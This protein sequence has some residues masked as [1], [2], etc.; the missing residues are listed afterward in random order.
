M[1][2][3][4]KILVIDASI[5]GISGDMF[6]GALI[7][8]GANKKKVI[9]LRDFILRYVEGVKD[10]DITVKDVKRREFRAKK[11]IIKAVD[12]KKYRHGK[13]VIDSIVNIVNELDL[14]SK[15]KEFAINTV[16]TLVGVEAM[17]HG[18]SVDEVHLHEAGLADTIVDIV[19]SAIALDDLKL[20]NAKIYVTPVAVGG[21][22]IKISH[23]IITSPAPATLEI[24]KKSNIHVIGG[25]IKAELT[26]PTGASLL[27]NLV[28]EATLF[29]PHLQV[30]RVG[31]GAGDKDFKEIPNILRV[32]LGSKHEA[33]KYEEIMVIETDI[34]DVTGEV[35]GYLVD[36]LIAEG[37]KDVSIIPI[38]RKK[39]RPGYMVRVI[40][41]LENYQR[42]T[43]IIML[44]T[45]TLGVRYLRYARHIVP[46]REI[47][48]VKVVIN[49]K[50]YEVKVKISRDYQ[51]NI[52]GLKPEYD[53][54]KE[55]ALKANIPLR[56]VS[57]L[58]YEKISKLKTI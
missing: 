16:K 53:S 3:Y 20:F 38:Y 7:D 33:L 55:V 36:K 49:G 47:K 19:G 57:D 11:V 43:R 24:L 37:A 27:V 22:R 13:E 30:E 31:Y 46:I 39:N 45:G 18:E 2:N 8:L 51:G 25:P 48:P 29:Y 23:G 40:S 41:D 17:I 21:G 12:E 34:D 35:V 6:L 1:L 44:E 54:I 52:I 10:I 58:V 50:E 5:A 56:K 14:S 26:T 15:A 9:S 4:E 42:L 32:V 28:H